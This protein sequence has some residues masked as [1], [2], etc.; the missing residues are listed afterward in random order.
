MRNDGINVVLFDENKCEPISSDLIRVGGISFSFETPD[1]YQLEKAYSEQNLGDMQRDMRGTGRVERG[2]G[3]PREQ[4]V[5]GGVH[6]E[7]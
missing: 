2:D 5:G 1:I 3:S 7:Q 4:N 6:K